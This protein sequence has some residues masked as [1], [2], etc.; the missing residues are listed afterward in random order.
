MR[1]AVISDVHANATAFRAALADAV[2]CGADGAILLGD[3]VGYGPEPTE[4]VA[5]ARARA[6]VS[7]LGNHDAAVA[8]LR[9]TE[10]FT[11]Y[12]AESVRIHHSMLSRQD[13]AYLASLPL[14]WTSGDGLFACAHGSF[15]N[16]ATFDY[17][18]SADDAQA[19]FAA[20][21]DQ[22]LI[23]ACFAD[24]FSQLQ[25]STNFL[26]AAIGDVIPA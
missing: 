24:A 5:L 15:A 4:A 26:F 7:L 3:I 23:L 10:D 12:A 16:P 22:S 11:S 14:V 1:L 13:L 21:L 9:N 8:G 17:V 20:R 2:A 25:T 6:L 19:S 18:S